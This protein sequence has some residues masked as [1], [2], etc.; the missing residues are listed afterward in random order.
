MSRSQVLAFI[1]RLAVDRELQLKVGAA[2][3]SSQ[4]IKFAQEA[5]FDFTIEEFRS[6]ALHLP[7]ASQDELTDG[8]LA[9][10]SGG[11]G[12]LGYGNLISRIIGLPDC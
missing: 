4:V 8:D 5:G 9:V 1:E 6:T 10:V 2:T 12:S 7:T 3:N 11:E